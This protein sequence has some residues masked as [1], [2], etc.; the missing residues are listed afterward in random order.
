[1]LPMVGPAAATVAVLAFMSVWNEYNYALVAMRSQDLPALAIGIADLAGKKLL[2]G[3][4]PVFAAMVLA[5]LPVC[6]AFLLAQRSFL[7]YFSLGGG[8]V[9]QL[10][11]RPRL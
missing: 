11:Q 1:M 8:V 5:S 10:E 2:Y 7:R 4:A 9:R 3:Y 6:I